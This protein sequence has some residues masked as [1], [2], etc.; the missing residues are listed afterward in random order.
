M[1]YINI[2][3]HINMYVY[4]QSAIVK[5]NIYGKQ[6]VHIYL[7]VLQTMKC[8][9]SKARR[10]AQSL[11]EEQGTTVIQATRPISPSR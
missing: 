4:I 3:I 2:I 10:R 8:A 6:N 7:S 1:Y 5:I 9:Q 11:V